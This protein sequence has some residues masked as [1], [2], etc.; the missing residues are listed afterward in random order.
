MNDN[1][2]SLI[3]LSQSLV[4]MG[5]G[6]L[7]INPF[8]SEGFLLSKVAMGGILTFFVSLL[9]IKETILGKYHYFVYFLTLS[10]YPKSL[11]TVIYILLRLM[12]N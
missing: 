7:S 4:N 9:N 3:R 11:F 12:N 8:Y 6:M 5:N 1:Y 10:M 2:L